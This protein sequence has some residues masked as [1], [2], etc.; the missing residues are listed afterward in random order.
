MRL[1]SSPARSRRT[2]FELLASQ[3]PPPPPPPP[4]EVLERSHKFQRPGWRM[5]KEGAR[6]T[7]EW[8]TQYE[9]RHGGP[10]LGL[11]ACARFRRA[12]AAGPLLAGPVPGTLDEGPRWPAASRPWRAAAGLPS[13]Q[14]RPARSPTHPHHP[15]I[16]PANSRPASIVILDALAEAR[17]PRFLQD[18]RL[19][20][21]RC[22]GGGGAA[23]SAPHERPAMKTATWRR[24]R[25]CRR[26]RFWART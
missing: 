21:G 8:A 18:A 12:A 2:C 5:L 4:P 3:W 25:R 1:F 22:G 15:S 10:L 9:R 14:P 13:R 23:A 6:H 26:R 17:L 19:F 16:R 11:A 20:R 7:L 24:R